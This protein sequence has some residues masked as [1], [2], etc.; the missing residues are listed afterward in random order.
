MHQS[1]QAKKHKPSPFYQDTTLQLRKSV[2]QFATLSNVITSHPIQCHP[3]AKNLF[4]L[5]VTPGFFTPAAELA[6][7]QFQPRCAVLSDVLCYSRRPDNVPRPKVHPSLRSLAGPAKYDA[8]WWSFHL[9]L[10]FNLNLYLFVYFHLFLSRPLTWPVKYDAC[11]DHLENTL[12]FTNM[13]P[14]LIQLY[15]E[16]P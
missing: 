15:Y 12:I 4:A 1:Y 9:Y 14:W 10:Y 3:R 13:R 7:F 6:T 8:K 16:I 5:I 2:T 11:Y